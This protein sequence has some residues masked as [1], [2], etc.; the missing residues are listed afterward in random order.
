MVFK[1]GYRARQFLGFTLVIAAFHAVELNRQFN[2][3]FKKNNSM[4][5]ST[6]MFGY[7]ERLEN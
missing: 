3:F 1:Y 2:P 5:N 4:I 6:K 7:S